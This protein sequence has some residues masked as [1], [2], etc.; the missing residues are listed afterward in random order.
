MKKA[1]E[2]FGREFDEKSANV[3]TDSD[4]VGP[5]RILF[6]HQIDTVEKIRKKLGKSPHKALLHMPTGSGKTIS[7]MRVILIHLLEN[8]STSVIWLAYNEELCEQAMN[9]F[10]RMWCVA[11]DRKIKTYRFFGKSKVN[12]SKVKD[13]FYSCKFAKNARRSW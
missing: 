13:G 6:Q 9:E 3:K 2:F 12:L 8:P 5:E 1:L 10:Q 4:I 11:G 7:A